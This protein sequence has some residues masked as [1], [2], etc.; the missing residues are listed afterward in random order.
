[1]PVN[2]AELHRFQDQYFILA[3]VENQDNLKP[4]LFPMRIW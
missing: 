4:A 2:D 1:M 3:L